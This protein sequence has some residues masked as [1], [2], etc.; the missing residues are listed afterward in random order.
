[1]KKWGCLIKRFIPIDKEG[2]K[3]L[4]QIRRWLKDPHALRMEGSTERLTQKE[5][6][7]AKETAVYNALLKREI[8]PAYQIITDRYKKG[9]G[10]EITHSLE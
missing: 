1:M 9:V 10:F 6:L 7:S 2:V 8:F 5:S 3:K 4:H